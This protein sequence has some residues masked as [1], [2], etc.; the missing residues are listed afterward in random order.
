[1]VRLADGIQGPLPG[2]SRSIHDVKGCF[3]KP[4]C[5]GGLRTLL[6]VT[7]SSPIPQTGVKEKRSSIP[8]GPCCGLTLLTP[9][10]P[11]DSYTSHIFRIS[12]CGRY[13]DPESISVSTL[14]GWAR[15]SRAVPALFHGLGDMSVGQV[16]DAEDEKEKATKSMKWIDAISVEEPRSA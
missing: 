5:L 3:S 8:L 11:R 9:V 2:S 4:I 13:R 12:L 10:I 15:R 1:M 16:Y 14:T 7:F 6:W